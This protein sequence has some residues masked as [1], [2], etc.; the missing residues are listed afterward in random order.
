MAAIEEP[1]TESRLR[2]ALRERLAARPRSVVAPGSTDGAPSATLTCLFE[3]EGDTHV[4][5]MKRPE[6]MRRHSG[7]VAFPGGKH[8]PEDESLLHTALRESHEE[9][10]LP[11]SHVDV[12]GALDDVVT[13]T[14]FVI[15]PYVAWL[16]E[17]FEPVPNPAEVARVFRAPLRIFSHKAKGVFPRVGWQV[18]GELVWGATAAVLRNLVT[19]VTEIRG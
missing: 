12:L 6:T 1:L 14:G 19:V 8:D 2:E 4:W 15:T 11:R 5:L 10:G 18:E 9:L 7:Q 16:R 13:F 3:H 17:P